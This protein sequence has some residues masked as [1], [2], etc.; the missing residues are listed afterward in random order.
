MSNAS[1][2]LSAIEARVENGNFSNDDGA[3]IVTALHWIMCR[4]MT[5]EELM[6]HAKSVQEKKR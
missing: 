3:V 1:K 5:M 2:V 4:L 6:E